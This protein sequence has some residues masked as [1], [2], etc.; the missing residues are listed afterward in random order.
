[1]VVSRRSFW[2]WN[3]A[4]CR[5][6]CKDRDIDVEHWKE[7]DKTRVFWFA[8]LVNAMKHCCETDHKVQRCLGDSSDNKTW[9]A[10]KFD[11]ICLELEGDPVESLWDYKEQDDAS[12]W[13]EEDKDNECLMIDREEEKD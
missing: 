7:L 13:W 6:F 2:F 9:S 8:E 4:L 11:D 3:G 10:E 1:M 12:A 5:Q